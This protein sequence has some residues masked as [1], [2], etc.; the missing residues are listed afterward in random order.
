MTVFAV[1]SLL[2][3]VVL[4]FARG[5]FWRADQRLSK[6]DPGV[7]STWPRV[8]AVIPAR[9]EAETIGD[10]VGAH[11]RADYPGEFSVILVDDQSGD[12]TAEIA[13]RA[14]NTRGF[15]VVSGAP[16]PDGWS[17][18]VWAMHQGLMRAYAKTPEFVL[19]TDAD[20]VLKT[21]TLRRLVH[22]AERD[23]RAL[24]SLMA[25]LDSRG[26]WAGLFIPAFIYFFQKLYPFPLVNARNAPLAGAAGGC[27][28]VRADA[29]EETGGVE[30]FRNALIDDCALARQIKNKGRRSIW[31]G[32]ATDEAV[33]LR[34]NR[35]LASI[36]TMVA[37]TAFTQLNY[38]PLLLAGCVAGMA[39]VYLMPPLAFFTG[40]FSGDAVLG[41]LGL[42]AWGLSAFSFAPTLRLYEKPY[43][44]AIALPIAGLIYTAMTIDS[45][46][47][48]WA[49]AGGQWKGR[50]YPGGAQ[51]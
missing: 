11:D 33:S 27:M 21:D 50:T 20:I 10:V 3:W 37:R 16:L 18:K 6:E 42:G 36:W 1:L 4:V 40:L 39:L 35:E 29:L 31:L 48:H 2:S 34:D 47:R 19:F 45:A 12:G 5:R 32:L 51:S 24:V 49:G 38:S 43:W 14:A 17:G 8:V 28:L 41:V 23:D 9:N 13:R 15:E 44:L 7:R 25:R 30:P 26:G 46:R 22:K